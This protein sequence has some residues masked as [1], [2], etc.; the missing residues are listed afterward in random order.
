MT[1]CGDLEN[2]PLKARSKQASRSTPS[3]QAAP[4]RPAR[5]PLD[6]DVVITISVSELPNRSVRVSGK[7]NLPTGTNLMLSVD[8]ILSGG[9]RGQ[10]KCDVAADGTFESEAFGSRD[11]LEDGVYLAEVL[12]PIPAVQPENV[13]ML[14]GKNGERLSRDDC[15]R[16]SFAVSHDSGHR[17][18]RRRDH[19]SV[20]R[21][22]NGPK[23]DGEVYPN[24]C[25]EH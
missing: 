22:G 14:L 2:E 12:M 17:H 15:S 21:N 13:K 24:S 10:S 19:G 20:R 4:L 9:F 18:Q 16:P 23:P 3:I 1:G 7:T 25:E 6:S 8:E 5:V 11:G